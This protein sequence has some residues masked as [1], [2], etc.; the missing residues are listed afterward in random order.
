MIPFVCFCF[1]VILGLIVLA[2]REVRQF[3]QRLDE[4]GER[5]EALE[6]ERAAAGA[7]AT[8]RNINDPSKG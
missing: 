7:S 2:Y 4:I 3:E 6:K 1:T 5:V 8:A